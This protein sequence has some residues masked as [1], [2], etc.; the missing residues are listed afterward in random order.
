GPILRGRGAQTDNG[1][2]EILYLDYLTP[3]LHIT[4]AEAV[5]RRLRHNYC[6]IFTIQ[7]VAY[8]GKLLIH[9]VPAASLQEFWARAAIGLIPGQLVLVAGIAFQATSIALAFMTFRSRR[10]AGSARRQ[11]PTRDR[12]LMLARGSRSTWRQ[13]RI[14]RI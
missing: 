4:Y 13:C 1:W 9:P 10:G 2:N 12:S 14:A 5:G 3:N 11:S 7:V 6:W 8:I